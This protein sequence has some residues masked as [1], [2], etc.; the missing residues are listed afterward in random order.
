MPPRQHSFPCFF[1]FVFLSFYEDRVK[2]E[3]STLGEFIMTQEAR[4]LWKENALSQLSRTYRNTCSLSAF[5]I[6]KWKRR[7]P[8][9]V[10]YS[11]YIAYYRVSYLGLLLLW[12][13]SMWGRK[14]IIWLVLPQ[15]CSSVKEVRAGTQTGQAP[16]GR[17]RCEIHGGV[18]L[19]GLLPLASS[20]WFLI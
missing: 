5:C 17:S 9:Q 16:G 18:L 6:C 2:E 14:G 15:H 1:C 12:P 7:I 19:I 20:A 8:R 11:T 10:K 3:K 4:R 13:K